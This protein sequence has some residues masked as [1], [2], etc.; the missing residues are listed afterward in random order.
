MN[1]FIS[2]KI[3]T[4]CDLIAEEL[5]S[6]RKNFNI[7][8]ENAAKVTGINIRYLAMLESGDFNSLPS[9]VYGR[10]FLRE[11]A[12]FLDLDQKELLSAYDKERS[13]NVK[14]NKVEFTQKAVII[15]SSWRLS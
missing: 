7:T 6:A 4:S 13:L 12:Q 10:N 3:K 9:G 14:D 11:Y 2:K 15:L 1:S 5:K 8:L